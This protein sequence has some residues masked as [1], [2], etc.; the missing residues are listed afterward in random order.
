MNG[1]SELQSVLAEWP[2]RF[3]PDG[4][5]LKDNSIRRLFRFL[6]CLQTDPLYAS[7]GDIAGLI[8]HVLCRYR[9]VNQSIPML[10]VP[11]TTGW[12]DKA[13]W[14]QSHVDAVPL[15]KVLQLSVSKDWSTDWLQDSTEHPPLR[16]AFREEERRKTWPRSVKYPLDPA[17]TDGLELEF[18]NYSSPGQRQAIHS[19]FLMKPGGTLVVNL[20]TGTGKSLVAWAPALQHPQVDALTVMV[21]PTIALAIDQERQLKNGYPKKAVAKLPQRL[22]WHS[23]LDEADRKLIRQ[24]LKNG[25]QRVLI[26][27]PESLMTSLARPLYEAAERGCLK[28]FVVDE[29][30]LVAQWGAEFRPQ[31][32]SISGL[33][34]ELLSQCPEDDQFKTLLLSATLSQDSV[35]MLRKLFAEVEIDH[36]SAVTLRPEP[37]Y[38]IS[39]APN[40]NE[41]KRRIAEL[42]RVVPRPFLLYVTK[43]DD[44]ENWFQELRRMGLKRIG[45]VHGSSSAEIRETAI[46]QWRDGSL[47][48]VVA[49]SAFG[50]GMDKQD[51]RT[52]IHACIP[53]TVDRYY[54]EVGRGGRDGN[55]CVSFLVHTN[56]DL[57]TASGLA[58]NRIITL[59]KGLPR[60]EAM[61]DN[62]RSIAGHPGR[63]Q[64]DLRQQ[65][66]GVAGD[67]DE[68]NRWNL[69]TLVL[70]NRAG[71]IRIES[72]EPPEVAKNPEETNEQ[73]ERRRQESWEEYSMSSFVR[74]EDDDHRELATWI[75]KVEPV[76]QQMLRTANQNFDLVHDVLRGR[77]KISEV[78]AS[79]YRLDSNGFF[80]EPVLVCG[81]CPGCR[82]EPDES[83]SSFRLPHP[84][85][86]MNLG[87]AVSHE[88]RKAL[89][90]INELVLVSCPKV[91]SRRDLRKF[92][93]KL[94]PILIRLVQWGVQEV[95]ACSPYAE[96]TEIREL[97]RSSQNQFVVH[98]TGSDD[99]FEE[100]AP[101]IP[102]ITLH[103]PDEPESISIET[104]NLNRP[105]HFLF[106]WEDTPDRERANSTIFERANFIR[107]NDLEARLSQ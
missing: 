52:I 102:A 92:M 34:R 64:V 45:C 53:E 41:R 74:I 4:I 6:K 79:A 56:T 3:I 106:A 97:Y 8:R 20:P 100:S 93:Q 35:D 80:V 82:S 103:L 14:Q 18:E 104:I 51:V 36:V 59:E 2:E 88:L 15:G 10:R 23:G 29:A 101:R 63:L 46:E 58:R 13:L 25:T 90:E 87:I 105:L 77:R 91:A 76:R 22:A 67:S 70:L 7:S 71:I 31:F 84:D 68:N 12:P 33:R 5:D 83:K 66:S 38:W 43:Q 16:G 72:H 94:K 30:H 11:T 17:L 89:P 65:T 19:A 61:V 81:G 42:V 48:A 95:A 57:G 54:Q 50:L 78:L 107:F 86:I 60:W 75:Q 32:Q 39:S 49:T 1:F 28:Y 55:A 73:F 21:T 85:A 69:R 9:S 62:G 99:R 24:N 40:E 47:D 27:S 37:E 26:A 98:R 44:A 96:L